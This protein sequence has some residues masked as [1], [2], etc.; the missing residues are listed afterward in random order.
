MP[1]PN[2]ASVVTDVTLHGRAAE[3]H[4]L[5][6]HVRDG[7][8]ALVLR[9]A[10]GVG[11]TALLRHVVARTRGYRVVH[12]RSSGTRPYAGLRQLSAAL[13][14]V[15]GQLMPH[16]ALALRAIT[17][18]SDPFAV[19]VAATF[20]LS[21]A[22][23]LLCVV[24][25]AH[26][27]DEPSARALAFVARRLPGRR[28]V[29]LFAERTG[30]GGLQD[31][32]ELVVP[33]LCRAGA[34]ALVDSL[35]PGPVDEDVVE[36]F[37]A[38][39]R[40]NPRAILSAVT[41]FAPAGGFG[42]PDGNPDADTQERVLR[43]DPGGRTLLL[44]AAADPTGQVTLLWQAAARLGIPAVAPDG[45]LAFGE[46]VTFSDPAA[47]GWVYHRAT[48]SERRTVHRA[49][50]DA[51]TS[52]DRRSWHRA[53]SV[54]GPDPAAADG[55]LAQVPSARKRGGQSAAA[56]FVRVAATLTSDPALR[57]ERTLAA[58]AA[59]LD[60]GQ[61]GNALQLLDAMVGPLEPA[62][63][64]EATR[65]RAWLTFISTRT[66]SATEALLRA[67]RDSFPFGPASQACLDALG[68]AV[69][70]GVDFAPM[71]PSHDDGLGAG[72][73]LRGTEG[74]DAA[75]GPLTTALETARP[76]WPAG[77]VAAELW[78]DQAW[79]RLVSEAA[80]PGALPD[81]LAGKALFSVHTG[82]LTEA[83]A[84]DDEARTM[85][86]KL[87]QAPLEHATVLVAAWRGQE[88]GGP[89]GHGLAR[90]C[91][92]LAAAV[93]GNAVG[94]YSRALAAAR[95]VVERDELATAGWALVEL[96]EAAVGAGRL[97]IA[98]TAL[99]A[100]VSRTDRCGTDWALGAQARSRALSA[101]GPEAGRL[102][103]EAIERLARTRIRP[104]LARTRLGYGEWLR[105]HG[106][107]EEA[108]EPLRAAY[109][110]FLRMGATAFADR[111]LL[112]I[113]EPE[114]PAITT[115]AL[116]R[117]EHRIAALARGGLT[118]SE[119]GATL[120]I[121]PRT[122]EYHL[123][124]VFAKLRITSRTE[125]HLAFTEHQHGIE[126]AAR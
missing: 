76:S 115:S 27:L 117:H 91:G 55:L 50:A 30:F 21:A 97:D 48:P 98:T 52:E 40:G 90:T 99:E 4:L 14:G 102:Y 12:V 3:V 111:A 105:R 85:S 93:A 107:D 18:D 7:H 75:V 15:F 26:R 125:L 108:G 62:Q 63:R 69:L 42:L 1:D 53:H 33:G 67:T 70:T 100:L 65:L 121:S 31:L 81:V 13:E 103:L 122:V 57:T 96:V 11:K 37:V 56:A 32:P 79:H 43:L 66:P 5:D 123:R 24:D 28:V 68:A 39:I 59:E 126:A 95:R 58:I 101:E 89:T 124:K 36:R 118:N 46:R 110:E 94:D 74:F 114:T 73:I 51:A 80:D 44:A 60:A 19:G 72:L 38:E 82:N 116:T 84:L 6:Q 86:M 109:D 71:P 23:P 34:R 54:P 47:R 35:V 119:I 45:L 78:D 49:L 64:A 17:E 20:L 104:L 113:G 10:P 16:H 22:A 106:R 25:D 120:S 92:E 29:L 87:G 9:G 41:A 83:A 112:A 88:F 8:G 77:L 2:P 61:P